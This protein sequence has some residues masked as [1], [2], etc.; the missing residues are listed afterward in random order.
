MSQ[1]Y[2]AC[3]TK[4]KQNRKRKENRTK[5]GKV[6]TL[7]LRFFS[8]CMRA[9]MLSSFSRVQLVAIPWT[10]AHQIPLSMGFSRQKYWSQSHALLQETFLT[11]G[12]TPCLMSPALAGG[13]SATGGILVAGTAKT[14]LGYFVKLSIN[15]LTEFND[16]IISYFLSEQILSKLESFLR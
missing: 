8:L 5:I 3:N 9:S 6:S 11:Q 1:I 7:L 14:K 12:S 10:V 15:N 2:K 13:F 16:Q 4:E